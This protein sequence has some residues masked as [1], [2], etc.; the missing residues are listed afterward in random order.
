MNININININI[1]IY[2]YE[3][4]SFS[5]CVRL[6]LELLAKSLVPMWSL[7]SQE[8]SADV[9]QSRLRT[10]LAWAF[11]VLNYIWKSSFFCQYWVL[12]SRPLPCWAGILPLEALYQTF[13]ALFFS[14]QFSKEIVCIGYFW[15]RALLYAWASLDQIL[16]FMLPWVSRMTGGIHHIQPLVKTGFCKLSAWVSFRPWSSRYLPPE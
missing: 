10:I 4:A 2:I 12:N 13:F 3:S 16:L 11:S 6:W 14:L 1:Y 15:D 9:R 5:N 8:R 7:I